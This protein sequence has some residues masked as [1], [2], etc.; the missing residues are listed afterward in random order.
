MALLL[1]HGHGMTLHMYSARVSVSLCARVYVCECECVSQG[2]R[3][4]DEKILLQ[5]ISGFVCP[6]DNISRQRK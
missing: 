3:N 2:M 5:R 4:I 6:F 1:S